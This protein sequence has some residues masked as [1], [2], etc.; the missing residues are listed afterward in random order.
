MNHYCTD[1]GSK[2]I[3]TAQTLAP[4]ESLYA[5]SVSNVSQLCRLR[6]KWITN[7]QTRAPNKSILHRVLLQM[8]LYMQ[9]QAQMNHYC[10]DSGSKWISICRLGLKWITTAQTRAPNESL[11]RRLG[12]QINHYCAGSNSIWIITAQTRAPNESLLCRFG[13]QMIHYYTDWGSKWITTVQIRA[14]NYSLLHRLR[15]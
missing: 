13:L 6:L 14:P 11:L 7:V 9:T 5:D 8:N 2:W 4:N 15:L 12:L 10:A 1:S 3:T